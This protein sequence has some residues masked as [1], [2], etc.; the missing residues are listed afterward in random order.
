MPTQIKGSS[1]SLYGIFNSTWTMAKESWDEVWSETT[2]QLRAVPKFVKTVRSEKDSRS[3]AKN[4]GVVI[5]TDLV[6]IIAAQAGMV[7]L[8]S[9]FSSPGMDPS[10]AIS[11][12]LFLA[13]WATRVF[14]FRQS[15]E[16]LTRTGVLQAKQASIFD[17]ATKKSRN[18]LDNDVCKD[19]STLRYLKGGVRSSLTYVAQQQVIALLNKLLGGYLSVAG[20]DLIV[21]SYAAQV[22]GQLIIDYRLANDGL[23]ERHQHEYNWEF[24]ERIFALG[25][26]A[27]VIRKIITGLIESYT[28]VDSSYYG[29]MVESFIAIAMV[30]LA[31][32]IRLPKPVKESQRW[33]NPA[34]SMRSVMA[35]GLDKVGPD[36]IEFGKQMFAKQGEPFDYRHA[37]SVFVNFYK[38][39]KT[40]TVMMFIV[41][42]MFLGGKEFV[43]DEVV[44]DYWPPLQKSIIQTLGKIE[45][46]QPML[47]T[48]VVSVVPSK[49]L[50]P[51]AAWWLGAPKAAIKT[52]ANLLKND[53]VMQ[54]IG[55]LKVGVTRMEVDVNH[56]GFFARVVDNAYQYPP[57]SYLTTPAKVEELEDGEATVDVSPKAPVYA[58]KKLAYEVDILIDAIQAGVKQYYSDAT[59]GKLS[60]MSGDEGKKRAKFYLKLLDAT[61]P[62]SHKLLV[63]LAILTNKAGGTLL[64]EVTKKIKYFLPSAMSSGLSSARLR[65]KLVYELRPNLHQLLNCAASSQSKLKLLALEDH[66]RSDSNKS[67]VESAMIESVDK[68]YQGIDEVRDDCKGH[69]LT[70]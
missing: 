58:A 15:T 57:L 16:A 31:H 25:L 20:Y 28:G 68:I 5:A 69:Q 17:D 42:K 18:K 39:P 49:I 12:S 60:W 29:S 13:R 9:T 56:K 36:V 65:D 70:L 59:V 19:C 35:Y 22:I 45:D 47:T 4:A 23:C 24:W 62:Q 43:N 30:G 33:P 34:S 32:H 64:D 53:D 37:Y 1:W 41:P 48:G 7:A 50:N 54:L 55:E 61:Q 63:C 46:Y 2:E 6:P 21:D 27:V 14:T 44:R 10:F 26:P 66:I 40:Q 51:V 67:L 38:N 8:E 52:T 3:I 11:A